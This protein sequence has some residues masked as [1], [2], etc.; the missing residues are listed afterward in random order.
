MRVNQIHLAD[1][2]KQHQEDKKKTED[3][4]VSH[5]FFGFF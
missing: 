5:L 2:K 4:N 3:N 1:C